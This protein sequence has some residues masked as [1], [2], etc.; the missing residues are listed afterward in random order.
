MGDTIKKHFGKMLILLDGSEKALGTV[1]YIG[2]LSEPLRHIK[3]VLFH[4]F[5]SVPDCY[6]DMEREPKSVKMMPQLR[7]WERTKRKEIE[8]HMEKAVEILRT[9]GFQE[10]G[11]T[12]K[13]QNRK[14]GIARD[15]IR[16]AKKGYR[17]VVLR[18][19]GVGA[20]KRIILGS[21]ATKLIAKLSFIPI[22]IVG[23][24]PV[25]K[26]I[27]LPVDGSEGASRAVAF[28]TD[29]LGGYNFSVELVHIFREGSRKNTKENDDLIP[30][31]CSE[32]MREDIT[33]VLKKTKR[34]MI[35]SGFETDAVTWKIIF[36]KKS[37][38][39][40]IVQ[41]ATH[42]GCGGIV[43]GRSGLSKA[44]DFFIGRVSN[45]VI[46]LDRKQTV[47]IVS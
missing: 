16:E 43:M 18:R 32:T 30:E 36:G 26:N 21:V 33:T 11:I 22:V 9:A 34:Q 13:I 14:K 12:V 44:G 6:W 5:S 42:Q 39:K 46:H 15:I 27:L 8:S 1:R 25:T 2:N 23:Q 29:L 28:A 47:C 3:L 37:R 10:D 38:A 4:V 45:K 40:A 41:E 17:A 20:L 7:A 19:R 35:A 24:L 31:L